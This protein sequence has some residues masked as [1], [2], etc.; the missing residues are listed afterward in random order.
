M[1]I[2]DRVLLTL[3]LLPKRIYQKAGVDVLKLESIL[4]YK[5][6]M[7]DRRPTSM[8]LVKMRPGYS[9][10]KAVKSSSIF[11]LILN[12]LMGSVFLIAFGVGKD[13]ITHLTFYFS[14]F[15][16][17]LSMMLISDFTSVLIDIRDN[18]IIIP[19]PVDGKTVV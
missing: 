14:L 16:I 3:V 18:F 10:K 17:Y 8:E 2:I 6:L 19:K 5:L 11:V 13:N 9:Q 7:D 4:H 12:A 15:V 1:N